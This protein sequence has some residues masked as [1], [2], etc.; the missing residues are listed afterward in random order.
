MATNGLLTMTP[1][2]LYC[3]PG[4]FHI[5]PWKPVA[6]AVITHAHADHARRGSETY[7]ASRR[8]AALLRARLGDD[9]LV[10]PLELG[11][12]WSRQGVKLS[13]H[14][15]G[16]VLGSAQ[17]RVEFRGQVWVVSGDYKLDADPTCEPFQPVACDTFVTEATF[18]LPVY[19]WPEAG[20]VFGQINSW[21][22][23]NAAAGKTSLLFAYSLGKAQRVLAGIDP[24]IGPIFTHGAV[25]AVNEGYRAAGVALPET[26]PAKG[27]TTSA[28]SAGALVIAPPSSRLSPWSRRFGAYASGFVSGWMLIRGARR[29]RAVDRGFVISDHADWPGLVR[30]VEATRAR[31]V[32]ATH[33]YAAPLARWLREQGYEADVLE[34][35]F[36]GEL[37]DHDAEAA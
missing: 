26:K 12:V 35:R 36:V 37:D 24:A 19:R 29:R 4:D 21:W 25:E 7:I 31:R 22:R 23:R 10:R 18:A 3:E 8:G 11:E 32:L 30:A 33:G 17:V 16:H 2:G 6:R 5:D 28:D 15:A 14:P 13:L 27:I 1:E 9:A 20:A 34:T